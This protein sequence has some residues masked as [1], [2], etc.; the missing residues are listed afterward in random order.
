M[1]GH[2]PKQHSHHLCDSKLL[3]TG[4]VVFLLM[5]VLLVLGAS[6]GFLWRPLYNRSSSKVGYVNETIVLQEVNHFY[7][8]SIRI[9]K[10]VQKSDSPQNL[11][12]LILDQACEN[13]NTSD[14]ILLNVINASSFDRKQ[15]FSEYLM[16]GSVISY[17][18][19]ATSR[20]SGPEW[21]HITVTKGLQTQGIQVA[22]KVIHV[23]AHG[24]WK[25]TKFEYEVPR[26]KWDYY[27][28][29]LY[30][31]K[32]NQYRYNATVRKVKIESDI[33]GENIEGNCTILES[34]QNQECSLAVSFRG[35]HAKGC[36]IGSIYGDAD[37]HFRHRSVHIVV[38][39]GHFE[40][41]L[42]C[43]AVAIGLVVLIMLAV[44]VF[45]MFKRTLRCHKVDTELTGSEIRPMDEY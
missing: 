7:F 15:N 27:N 28:L 22:H 23:G 8:Q 14:M 19:N 13:L 38:T 1:T 43:T 17:E 40:R 21:M 42:A 36:L 32:E 39:Q 6:L 31:P 35:I 3:V 4:T 5:L 44:A 45:L 2:S 26:G 30:V 9:E 11:K 34:D 12:A 16:P 18:I 33:S 29:D 37:S 24:K 25:F 20:Y 41:G 10:D